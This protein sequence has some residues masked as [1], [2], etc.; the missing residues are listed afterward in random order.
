MNDA[1]FNNPSCEIW[2]TA[3]VAK[4]L[5]RVDKIFEFHDENAWQ[6]KSVYDRAANVIYRKDFPIDKLAAKYGEIF[7][8]SMTMI[9][10]YAVE[11]GYEY[12]DLYGVDNALDQEYAMF[13]PM[14]LYMLGI[15]KGQGVK[16]HISKGS[17]ILH[18]EKRY[19]YERDYAREK[20]ESMKRD[21]ENVKAQADEM[22]MR[23]EWI[24]GAID[25]ASFF[26]KL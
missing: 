5:P 6:D 1:P 18:P 16:I 11:Q 15:A 3:S 22:R 20:I 14:F 25:S 8:S 7:N 19:G 9:L 23:A 2:T 13:R 17:L 12:I 26:S 21:F 10:A 24:R 4:S